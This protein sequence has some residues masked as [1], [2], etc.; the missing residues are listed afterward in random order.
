MSPFFGVGAF[1]GRLLL[2]FA[3]ATFEGALSVGGRTKILV[4]QR[5]ALGL[6]RDPVAR[7]NLRAG[8]MTK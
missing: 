5:A 7:K 4:E 1:S 3:I 8:R 2:E 6:V